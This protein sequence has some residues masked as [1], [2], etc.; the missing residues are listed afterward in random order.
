VAG[1]GH[2]WEAPEFKPQY[3]QKRKKILIVNQ[4]VRIAL[5]RDL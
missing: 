3:R 5:A 2:K 4:P 1:L